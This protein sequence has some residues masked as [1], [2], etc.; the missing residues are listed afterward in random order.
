MKHFK[1]I[2][3]LIFDFG[4]V[5]INLDRELCI[6]N[7]K[8]LGVKNLDKLLNNYAQSGIFEQFEKGQINA[9]KFR[10]EIRKMSS[11]TLTDAQ[12]DDAWSSFLL[13]IPTEKLDLLIE[14]RKKYR[15][16]LLSNTNS[17]HIQQSNKSRFTYQNRSMFDYFDKC[18]LSYEMGMSKPN[19]DIFETLLSDAQLEAEECLLLDDGEKNIEQAKKL[20]IQT[21][22]VSEREDLSFLMDAKTFTNC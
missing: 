15:I 3:T 12:I 18:Y 4:G 5:L 17:I 14:L 8:H 21:Y 19:A 13:D 1:N 7:F 20:G 6:Q 22:L 9:E 10:D 16:L 11:M 2:T